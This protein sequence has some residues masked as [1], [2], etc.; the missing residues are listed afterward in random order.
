MTF[1]SPLRYPGGKG[2]LVNYFKKLFEINSLKGG[3]YVEPY[4]GG[5]SVALSLLIEDYVSKVII[6]D[7]DKSIFALW[8]S[9]LNY[10]EELCSL[11]KKTS[12][13]LDVWEKQK[14]I[15]KDKQNQ[16]ILTLGFSTLFLNRT[17]YSGILSAGV[18]GGKSQKGRWKINARFNKKD[19]IKRIKR[20]SLY[21]NKIK[22]YN[23]DA[24]ELIKMLKSK[25]SNKTLFYLDP[26]YY[27]KGKELY[28]NYY[29]D[30]DHKQIAVEIK[31]TKKQKWII[32][33]DNAELIKQL[34]NKNK[35]IGYSLTYSARKSKKGKELM[36]FS[37]NLNILDPLA[38]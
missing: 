7:K 1:Y 10:P 31:K 36:I 32:T 13:N 30:N 28:L 3:I 27:H 24:V 9:V 15:Q 14:Q 17:N 18:I 20:I 29:L 33:Y 4:V 5:A 19:L 25:L 26:P 8:Y 21:K 38:I 2:K 35:Q 23:M 12:V 37:D 6:N 22:L 34:Y 11:I 16:D